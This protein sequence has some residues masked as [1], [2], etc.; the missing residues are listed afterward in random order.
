MDPRMSS[1]DFYDFKDYHDRHAE[2][3]HM[4]PN[5]QYSS[6]G[7]LPIPSR[8]A[9]HT[10]PPPLPPP[11]RIRDLENGYDAGWLYANS[12]RSTTSLPPI[13]PN[14]SL[15]GGHAHRRP[16][17]VPRSDR[18]AVDELEGRQSG[19]PL[20]RSP[21]AQIKIEPPPPTDDGFPN[22]MSVN[23]TGPM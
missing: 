1:P 17:S 3:I 18:M 4:M 22:T 12:G 21:E 15:F 9:M 16:D 23:P 19:L 13:S 6:H 20:S 14:S 8:P 5:Q 7:P 11:P 10:A 2:R